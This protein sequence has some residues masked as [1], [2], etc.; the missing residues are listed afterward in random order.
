MIHGRHY[1]RKFLSSIC[2][3]SGYEFLSQK[4]VPRTKALSSP[5]LSFFIISIFQKC[6][7]ILRTV[8][9]WK[10]P[11]FCYSGSGI[12]KFLVAF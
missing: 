12:L 6:F 2:L 9:T 7:N 4:P 11:Q 8:N 3:Q 5:Q 1:M 10:L